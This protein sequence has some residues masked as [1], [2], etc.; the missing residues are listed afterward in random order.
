MEPLF[1]GM[2]P[3]LE[4]PGVWPGFHDAFLFC[5][6]EALQP[7]LPDRYYAELRQREEVGLADYGANHV[8]FPDVAVKQQD[9]GSRGGAGAASGVATVPEHIVIASQEPLIV[10]FVEIRES[11]AGGRLVAVIELVSPSNKVAGDDREAFE[12]KQAE[13][14]SSDAHWIEIDL[15]RSGTRLGGNPR[16]ALHCRA[17]GHDYVVV[18]SRSEKRTPQLDL[19]VYGFTV[20]DPLPAVA[21]PLRPPDPDVRLEL[22]Q[23][24]RRAYETGPYRK[25]LRYDLPADPALSR[26]D[27]AWARELL[28]ARGIE[29]SG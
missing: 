7:V 21:I 22:G 4:A 23:A 20:H 10:N 2:D 26:E 25:I 5:V 8:V 28:R 1:P 19:E 16:V 3:Y 9:R 15:L 12:R 6:R 11:A 24:F 14:F 17:R 13:I 29:G 27:A 18:V